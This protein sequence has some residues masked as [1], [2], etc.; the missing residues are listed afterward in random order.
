MQ[1]LEERKLSR[2]IFKKLIKA[3]NILP[4]FFLLTLLYAF[5]SLFFSQ[6]N[7]FRY[8]QAKKMEKNLKIEISQLEKENHQLKKQIYKLKHDR[9]TIEKKARENLGLIKEGD[10]IYIVFDKN[11]EKKENKN[12]WIDKIKNIYR[13]YYL[14]N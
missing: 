9:Y 3:D 12:R 8:I 14:K 2:S 1:Y 11:S 6:N 13:E 10:E 5:L 7:I 4:V